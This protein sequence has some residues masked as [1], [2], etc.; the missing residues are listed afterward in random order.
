MKFIKPIKTAAKVLSLLAIPVL[1]GCESELEGPE[2]PAEINY[3]GQLHVKVEIEG[4]L[5][6]TRGVA[7]AIHETKLSRMFVLFFDPENDEEYIAY[8]QIDVRPGKNTVAFDPPSALDEGKEYRVLVL[9][10]SDP[11]TEESSMS[12]ELSRMKGSYNDLKGKL[13]ANMEDPVTV[14]YPGLLPMF[15]QYVDKDGDE[16][17]FSFTRNDEGNLVVDDSKRFFL[18]RAICRFDIENLV[19]QNLDI[20]CARVINARTA[21]YYFLNGANAGEQP[22]FEGRTAPDGKG[23]MPITSNMEENG[24]TTQ[25]LEASLYT[26]PNKVNVT[27]VNDKVTTGLMIAGY[28]TDPKTMVKDTVLTYYRFN[29]SNLGDCQLLERN[30][31][32]KATIK[33]VKRRGSETEDEAYNDSRP[34]FDYSV[35]TDW[36]TT[37]DNVVNDKDG[38]FLI[39]NKT[40]L[41]FPGDITSADYVELRVSTN[42]ELEWHAEWYKQEGDNNSFFTFDRIND[43]AVKCGPKYKND[44]EFVRYGYINIVGVNNKTGAKLS[45]LIYLAQLSTRYDV[46]TLSVNGNTGRF[47]LELNPAGDVAHLQVITGTPVTNW[48]AVDEGGSLAAFSSHGVAFTKEGGNKNL[49][50]IQVPANMHN[51]DNV[52]TLVVSLKENDY[53]DDGSKKVQDVII[54]IVQK[55]SPYLMDVVGLPESGVLDIECFTTANVNGAPINHKMLTVCLRDPEYVFDVSSTFDYTRDLIVSTGTKYVGASAPSTDGQPKTQY[56]PNLENYTNV[57]LNPFCTGPDD[58]QI[59]GTIKIIAHH[60][61][62]PNMRTEERSYTVRLNTTCINDDV[63]MPISGN[64]YQM[65]TDRNWGSPGK[66]TMANPVKAKNYDYRNHIRTTNG[67]VLANNTAWM[68]ATLEVSWGANY[69]YVA[70]T[71]KQP[72]TLSPTY[73]SISQ[74]IC[75]AS[76]SYNQYYQDP[77][78]WNNITFHNWEYVIPYLRTSKGRYFIVSAFSKGG[79]PVGCWFPFF[80]QGNVLCPSKYGEV[81]SATYPNA[82]YAHSGKPSLGKQDGTIPNSSYS[83]YEYC[84][85]W[86]KDV[87]YFQHKWQ[88]TSSFKLY[89]HVRPICVFPAGYTYFKVVYG[90]D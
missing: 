38:N 49:L 57:W 45:K 39:V 81:L 16:A 84:T 63:F 7:A 83:K 25:R 2:N 26:F 18:S 75:D 71:P 8:K 20:R 47:R 19:G 42:P 22:D 40:H 90:L 86:G 34:I 33:G 36:D 52:G 9:G 79:K 44:T 66:G 43:H 6:V 78:L 64:R 1:C 3:D 35:E 50:T 23:Y 29:M 61:S 67:D 77:A 4:D 21:G 5:S 10:N 72:F 73:E 53:N 15:G 88:T 11:Y 17:R 62:D 41:S 27:Q 24:N 55:P 56:V 74:Q 28:Y 30:Y 54:E 37:D 85:P 69:N 76:W 70:G 89:G 14:K 58:P 51:E 68:G 12:V 48:Q 59:T 32:Y 46:K 65:V 80:G 31:R 82:L 60:K 13:K 87:A